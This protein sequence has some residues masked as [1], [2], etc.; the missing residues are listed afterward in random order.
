MDK[1][2][3]IYYPLLIVLLVW[4]SGIM[5]KGKW[6]D[7]ALSFD[8][9]KSLLGFAEI[10]IILHHCSHKS[11]AWWVEPRYH[12]PGLEFFASV[13]FLCVALFF[14]C[15]GYGM[16]KSMKKKTDFFKGYFTKRIPHI[17]IPTA[18]MWLVCFFT[19]KARGLDIDRPVWINVCSHLWYIY[20]LIYAYLIF[21]ISFRLIKNEKA[22]FT[23]LWTGIILYMVLAIF[24]SPGEWWYNT[25]YLFP[26]GVI[27]ARNEEKY[28]ASLK[29]LYPLRIAILT[30]IFAAAYILY[31]YT[32]AVMGL[33]NIEGNNTFYVIGQIISAYVFVA[34]V[35]LIGLKVRIGNKALR[36]LGAM[37]LEMYVI[38]PF[39]VEAF[40]FEFIKENAKPLFYIENL[41]LYATATLILTL[42]PSYLVYLLRRKL[43]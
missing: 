24:F 10:V 41:F 39:F 25:V 11:S 19:E 23:F 40:C 37:T 36:L 2:I 43:K 1:L 7:D 35:I 31:L 28:I 5:R 14:F 32:D 30:V 26:I 38:H 21:F 8:Q 22:S 15:S 34:L 20:V 42:V 12:R 18:I 9:T 29:K 6:N 33:F 16:Y 4:G 17:L 27:F 3:Y 13:G